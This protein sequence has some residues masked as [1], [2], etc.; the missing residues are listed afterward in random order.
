M[1]WQLLLMLL[2]LVF[3]LKTGVC[4]CVLARISTLK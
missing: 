2:Q 3:G 1:N 4:R